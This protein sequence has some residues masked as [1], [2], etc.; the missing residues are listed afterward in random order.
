MTTSTRHL[1]IHCFELFTFP[2]L[3]R[4]T[5]ITIST[6]YWRRNIQSHNNKVSV[7]KLINVIKTEWNI[8]FKQKKT[9][10][11]DHEGSTTRHLWFDT[12]QSPLNRFFTVSVF[13]FFYL[14]TKRNFVKFCLIL[15]ILKCIINTLVKFVSNI[16]PLNQ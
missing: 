2:F 14:C 12:W 9:I 8:N 4:S 16:Y 3:T 10:Q 6:Y 13:D 11:G 7:K 15:M 5:V 1:H